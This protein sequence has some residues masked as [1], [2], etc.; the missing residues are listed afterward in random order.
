MNGGAEGTPINVPVNTSDLVEGWNVLAAEVH[1]ESN[2][3]SDLFFAAE[4]TGTLPAGVPEGSHLSV[5][6]PRS[7]DASDWNIIVEVTS[8]LATW[9]PVTSSV[10]VLEDLGATEMVQVFDSVPFNIT[11][12]RFIR[13]R[14]QAP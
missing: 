10:V 1:Q 8:D 12:R 3:S 9:S 6:F 7:K 13:I 2:T 11:D 4:F 14:V 5:K